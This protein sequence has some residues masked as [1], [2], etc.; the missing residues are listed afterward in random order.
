MNDSVLV[1]QIREVLAEPYGYVGDIAGL[2]ALRGEK[3][4]R[5][6]ALLSDSGERLASAIQKVRE[7]NNKLA[8]QFLPTNS[9]KEWDLA[10][11]I[12]ALRQATEA[13]L[14]ELEGTARR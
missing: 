7:T 5:I 9:E 12:R 2:G 8:G 6:R 14:T 13:L 10:R 1:H 3:L 11:D 4:D